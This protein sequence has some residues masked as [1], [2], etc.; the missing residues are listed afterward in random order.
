ML[1]E[2]LQSTSGGLKAVSKDCLQ[3]FLLR[4]PHSLM[5]RARS[6]SG[7]SCSHVQLRSSP[8]AAVPMCCPMG[9]GVLLLSYVV[10]RVVWNRVCISPAI[11]NPDTEVHFASM[12]FNRSTARYIALRLRGAAQTRT[13]DLHFS[14]QRHPPLSPRSHPWHDLSP[15]DDCPNVCH[16]VIEIPRG[17]KVRRRQTKPHA[18][19]TW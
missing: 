11:S 13:T 17:S 19:R 5:A 4:R 18:L 6:R 3:D 16:A 7:V 1:K 8:A 15:G 10:L 2:S 14:R 12:S 9:W